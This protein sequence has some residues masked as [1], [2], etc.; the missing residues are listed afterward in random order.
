MIF[1][2]LPSDDKK[3][4]K[5]PPGCFSWMMPVPLPVKQWL[6]LAMAISMGHR[7]TRDRCL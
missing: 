7:T 2:R 6:G 5:T 1:F 4:F 3:A